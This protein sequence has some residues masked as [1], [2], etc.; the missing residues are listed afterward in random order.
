MALNL[1]VIILTFNL[2]ELI[3]V[4][5]LLEGRGAKILTTT[6]PVNERYIFTVLRFT[7]QLSNI[8]QVFVRSG[9]STNVRLK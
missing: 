8:E 9:R 3:T 2:S 6:H 1:R 7:R 4:S 5:L